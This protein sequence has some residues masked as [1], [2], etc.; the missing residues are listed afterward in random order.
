M[1]RKAT[2]RAEQ[3]NTGKEFTKPKAK[4]RIIPNS[5]NSNSNSNTKPSEIKRR[6]VENSV[7]SK[8]QEIDISKDNVT[9]FLSNLEYR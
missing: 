8:D 7:E 6:K 5:N 4:A 1:K 9:I 3:E 2:P